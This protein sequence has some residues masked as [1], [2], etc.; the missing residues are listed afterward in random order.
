MAT[1]ITVNP[2]YIYKIN[3]KDVKFYLSDFW[4][5]TQSPEYTDSWYLLSIEYEDGGRI[6]RFGNIQIARGTGRAW[7][8]GLRELAQRLMSADSQT[9]GSQNAKDNTTQAEG[10]RN[11]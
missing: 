7:R 1:A 2:T 4:S 10:A 5:M 3:G 6:W 9:G 8:K 11:G